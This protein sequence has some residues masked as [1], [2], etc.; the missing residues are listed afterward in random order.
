M[1]SQM[2]DVSTNLMAEPVTQK[3]SQRSDRL[4]PHVEAVRP[5]IEQAEVISFDVFDTLLIRPFARP[6]DVFA[7]MERQSGI[8]GF[9]DARILAER[10]AREK[11][12]ARCG[13][14]EVTLD[15]IYLNIKL[16]GLGETSID[17]LKALELKIESETLKRSPAIGAIYD[18]ARSLGK[19]VIAISDM[20]LPASLISS[21][22]TKNDLSVDDVFVSCEHRASKH[23]GTLYEI[24]SRSIGVE[25]SR[26]AHF[27]DNYRADCSEA[28]KAGVVGYFIPSVLDQLYRDSRF[29]QTALHKLSQSSDPSHGANRNLFASLTLA[30]IAQ[31]RVRNPEAPIARLFGAMYGGPLVTGF[32]AWLST[33]M[34]IDQIAHLR[35]ATRDGYITKEIWDI[36]ALQGRASILQSSR[37]LTM[38]PAFY[39]AFEKEIGSVLNTSTACTLRE[40]IKRLGLGE[41]E[42]ELLNSIAVYTPLDSVLDNPAKIAAAMTALRECRP[43]WQRIAA[44]EMN[45]YKLYLKDEGFDIE[46]DAMADCGWALT[47]QRRTE[48]ILG[49]KFRGYYVGTLEHAYMHDDVRSFLFHQGQDK[50]W[51]RIAER[52]VELLELAFASSQEQISHFEEGEDGVKPVPTQHQ[53]QYEILIGN[54]VR[55]M[56]D[57]ERLFAG[58]FGPCVS[59]VTLTEMRDSLRDL[60]DSLVNMP[61]QYEYEELAL[62][63][64]SRELGASGFATIGTFW[65]TQNGHYAEASHISTW[66]D[67][68]RLGLISFRQEGLRL[69]WMRAK[70]VL[71]RRLGR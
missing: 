3:T 71:R 5:L 65:S 37:R 68:L 21:V 34:Q 16:A 7:L 10:L 12:H 1:G 24:A 27:G 36:L 70:R 26:I 22:L 51:V 45:A 20:Y 17:A 52:G 49:K 13:S 56:Q 61:T 6:I 44:R 4:P 60:F 48:L 40:C 15:E 58:H 47:S 35:L 31:F 62:L 2:Q 50:N 54:F 59:Y 39:T 23:E 18:F 11:N 32:A 9:H 14:A 53:K 33:V 42:A 41:G 57:E 69:T 55:Q 28:L 19:K 63:P 46:H 43:I 64:H 30:F 67:Y 29:N 8:E 25:T 38:V 66:R